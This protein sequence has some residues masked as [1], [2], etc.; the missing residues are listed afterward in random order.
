MSQ[1][2]QIITVSITSATSTASQAGFGLPMILAQ[3]THNT[4]KYRLYSSLAGMVTDGFVAG[5]PAYRAATSILSQDPHPTQFAIGRA[6]RDQKQ[7]IKL[8]P[9]VLAT[10]A[11]TVY[12]NGVAA[13]F[14]SDATPLA[15]EICAG[16]KIAID[17]LAKPVVVVDASPYI[18]IES[19]TIPDAF[20]FYVNN[21]YLFKIENLTPDLGG[22]NG[23]A[24]DLADICLDYNDWYMLHLCNQG[25]AVIQAAAAYIETVDKQMIVSSADSDIYNSGSTTDIGYIL[26]LAAYNNTSVIHHPKSLVTYPCCGWAGRCL[27]DDPGEITWAFKTVTGS[28]S[29]AY[30]DS[31][32]TAMEDKMVNYYTSY[33]SL[34]RMYWGT[35]ASGLFIDITHSLDF[36][37]SRLQESLF[38]LMANSKKIPFND[39]GITTLETV[40]RAVLQMC[41]GQGIL[42]EGFTVTVPKASDVS[43][44]DKALRKLTMVSF[45]GVFQGAIHSCNISGY[46]TA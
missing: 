4:D 8:T 10:T 45:N 12:V 3:H 6:T 20:S 41:V 25:T 22:A 13:T 37:K 29:I 33:N 30:T 2:D 24:Q 28:D 32:R 9:V 11:Y 19:S 36:M 18:T 43:A 15:A 26:H 7:K 5:E 14:T 38:T 31:E 27:P 23:V 1:L 42:N 34:P 21:R 35:G 40:V 17:A 46:V 39:V 44:P 16:L